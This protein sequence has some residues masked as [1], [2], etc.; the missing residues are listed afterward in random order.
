M[1]IKLLFVLLL[2]ICLLFQGSVPNENYRGQKEN[3]YYS[4]MGAIEWI[5]WY[6]SRLLA[7][8]GLLLDTRKGLCFVFVLW[9]MGLVIGYSYTN[10][11]CDSKYRL[12]QPIISILIIVT[13]TCKVMKSICSCSPRTYSHGEERMKTWIDKRQYSALR[14]SIAWVKVTINITWVWKRKVSQSRVRVTRVYASL[15]RVLVD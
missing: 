10:Y 12:F 13:A 6:Q 4:P 14:K 2:L 9:L 15:Q 11:S 5:P 3:Y 7:L 1:S 8:P